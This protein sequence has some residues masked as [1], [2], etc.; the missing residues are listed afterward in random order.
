MRLIA[1]WRGSSE[2]TSL[3]PPAINTPIVTACDGRS[4][5]ITIP[6]KNAKMPR[7][8]EV[9]ITYLGRLESV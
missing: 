8:N 7:I 5:K 9:S 3:R 4:L 6:A 2:A 1:A